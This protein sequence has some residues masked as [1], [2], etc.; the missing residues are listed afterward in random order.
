MDTLDEKLAKLNTEKL[1]PNL[2][3]PKTDI[4][5]P[6]RALHRSDIVLAILTK[7]KTETL[8]PILLNDLTLVDEAAVKHPS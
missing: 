3:S 7:S 1:D 5:L 6:T 4:R 2:H 8:D